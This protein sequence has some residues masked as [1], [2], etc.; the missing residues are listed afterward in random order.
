MNYDAFERYHFVPGAYWI[1]GWYVYLPSEVNWTLA[2]YIQPT[3]QATEEGTM[4]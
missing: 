4:K 2:Y 1:S 3:T